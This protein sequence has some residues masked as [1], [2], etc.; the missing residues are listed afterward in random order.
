MLPL[1]NIRVLDL[2]RLLPGP[3]C[4]MMLADF[5][6]EVIKV[7]EPKTGDY[8]RYFEPLTDENSAYF[9]TLNRNKKSV[10]IDLKSED[11][12]NQFL[13]LVETADVLVESFRPGVMKRLNLDYDSLKKLNPQLIYCSITGYG[14][15]G[16][17]SNV[18]GHDINFLSLAGVLSISGYKKKIPD[19]PATQIADI[20][21]GAYPA[22]V[23]ILLALLERKNT[24]QG[25]MI[26]ISMLDGLFPLLSLTL[27]KFLAG[28]TVER[29]TEL[30]NG[31]YACYQIYETKDARYL[32]VGAIELKFWK[33]FCEVIDRTEYIQHLLAPL[34][35]QRKMITDIQ[36]IIR[37][38]TLHEWMLVFEGKDCCVT[39][40]LHFDE[41]VSSDVMKE[42]AM[43]QMINQVPVIA[44]PI[45]LSLTKSS[46][47]SVAPKLGEH[48]NELLFEQRLGDEKDE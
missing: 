22:L 17:Y 19:I 45:K 48:N 15:T 28:D 24:N 40:V 5:G 25:Q 9:Q 30:L 1:K 7:E 3:F 34:V 33:Q 6:A 10:T 35:I 36:F 14:Q 29:E 23:G 18:A 39:P 37:E 38:K 21:A 20:A 27:P 43:I 26:D 2:S 47:R 8:L 16:R 12:K 11:G 4:T 13:T 31:G 44:N 41:V 42:R 46:V 32:S